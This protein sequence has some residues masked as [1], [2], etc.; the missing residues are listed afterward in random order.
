MEPKSFYAQWLL[1]CVL[2]HGWT[3]RRCARE[4]DADPAEVLRD[5]NEIC[6]KLDCSMEA[7][8]PGGRR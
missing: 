3:T 1:E 5:F 7:L 2:V 8:F 6:A 4:V